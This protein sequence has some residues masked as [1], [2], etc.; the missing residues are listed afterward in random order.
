MVDKPL[1]VTFLG[2]SLNNLGKVFISNKYLIITKENFKFYITILLLKKKFMQITITE[3]E[4][5]AN[6]NDYQLGSLVRQK[7]WDSKGEDSD[8]SITQVSYISDEGFDKCV[9]CARV[10]KYHHTT[11]I[12]LRRGYIEGAGQACDGGCKKERV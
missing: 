6:S 8:Q 10:T 12:D 2:N 1:P 9:I 4:I 3:Q 7:Y 11:P 5:L